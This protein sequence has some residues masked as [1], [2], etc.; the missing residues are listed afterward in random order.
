MADYTIYSQALRLNRVFSD[1]KSFDELANDSE[2]WLTERGYYE[3]AIKKQISR[4]QGH[5]RKHLLE[6]RKNRRVRAETN[7]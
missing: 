3:K 1:N 4:A 7:V 5:S 2:R 6:K